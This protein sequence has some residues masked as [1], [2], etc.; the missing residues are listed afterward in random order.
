MATKKV[1]VY[2]ITTEIDVCEG[3]LYDMLKGGD[4]DF[5]IEHLGTE[6]VKIEEPAVAEITLTLPE[7]Y[8]RLLTDLGY[9]KKYHLPGQTFRFCKK[10]FEAAGERFE[11]GVEFK[12]DLEK[13]CGRIEIYLMVLNAEGSPVEGTV[14]DV[15]SSK[16][17]LP[18]YDVMLNFYVD[19]PPFKGKYVR[20]FVE[21]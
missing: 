18:M 20:V 15:A 17:W 8:K 16:V 19:E 5:R 12:F 13:E 7:E 10:R 9:Y 14:T 21:G 3:Y 11:V 1:N 4:F 2:K 6:T